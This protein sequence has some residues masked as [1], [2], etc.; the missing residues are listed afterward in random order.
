MNIVI[1]VVS[2]TVS[3]VFALCGLGSAIALI[4]I[5]VILGVPFTYARSAG[6]FVNVVTT[7]SVTFYNIQ[8][9]FFKPKIAPPVIISS[10]AF[11]PL[12]AFVS[13]SI[14]SKIVGFAF[15]SFLIFVVITT[16]LPIGRFKEKEKI[17]IPILIFIGALSGFLSGLLGV[18]GGGV[19]LPLLLLFGMNPKIAITVTPLSVPFSSLTS[20]ITYVHLGG[21]DWEVIVFASIPAMISGYLAGYVAH[22]KLKLA[23][24]RKILITI[25][26]LIAVRFI[27][28]FL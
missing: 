25:L 17:S 11:A 26:L 4:P 13:I 10:I 18:G 2:F 19:I 3:F 5:L 9:G 20:F 28:K 22:R 8:S 21:V 24:V 16:T 6:L 1:P 14:P 7:L 23:T 15:V 27:L 12:G